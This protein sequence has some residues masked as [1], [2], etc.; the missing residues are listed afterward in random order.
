MMES[1]SKKISM[2]VKIRLIL[3]KIVAWGPKGFTAIN[4]KNTCKKETYS[5]RCPLPN[6]AQIQR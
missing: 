3:L 2:L 5:V 4:S 1:A 6:N